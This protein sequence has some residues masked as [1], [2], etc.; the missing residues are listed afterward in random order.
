MK[1]ILLLLLWIWLMPDLNSANDLPF[2]IQANFITM[3]TAILL[4]TDPELFNLNIEH[5]IEVLR[6]KSSSPHIKRT[7][8]NVCEIFQEFGPSYVRRAYRM[9]EM[10]FWKLVRTLR[11]FMKGKPR[12]PSKNK[13]SQKTGAKNGIIPTPTKVSVA[14]RWFAG[15]SA[16]DIAIMHGISHTDVFRCIW[17]V[18]D[19][20]NKCPELAFNFP[21]SHEEQRKIARGFSSKSKA[22]FDCCCGAVDGLLIWTDKPSKQSCD[23]A[24]CGEKKFFCGRKKIFGMN[25]Q[26]I[27]DHLGRFLYISVRHP[28]STSDYLSFSTM[29]LFKKL[30][31][32]GFLSPGWCLFG[33]NAYVSTPYMA[34]P[35]KNVKSGSKDNYNFYHSQVRIK[36][37]CAFGMLVQRWGVLRRPLSAKVTPQKVNCLCM[38]LCRLHNY[39]LNAHAKPNNEA[40]TP[41]SANPESEDLNPLMQD[42]VMVE[43]FGGVSLDKS[44]RPKELLHGGHHFED[45]PSGNMRQW[46]RNH[47]ILPREVMC[48]KVAKLG[49]KRP[50]P[51]KWYAKTP[52]KP[53]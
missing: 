26:G 38:A 34:T 14:L 12:Q 11:P 49:L 16:Y 48:E 32:R 10:A 21:E 15:G 8:K 35:Y 1:G 39:C 25:L 22:G 7:R 4:S 30:E 44:R 23:E 53:M 36:I 9:D 5:G 19:A 31:T 50:T 24:E 6:R 3:T 43:L 37:E 42:N 2:F 18:V 33:D 52:A 40:S 27:C 28:A 13:C 17:R 20:V 47:E 41:T 29:E 45:V 51:N 46:R